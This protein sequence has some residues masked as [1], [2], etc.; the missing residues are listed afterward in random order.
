MKKTIA[1]AS[2]AG[3]F[4]GFNAFAAE[5]IITMEGPVTVTTMSSSQPAETYILEGPDHSSYTVVVPPEERIRLSKVIKE[6]PTTKFRFDGT[7]SDEEGG[8]HMFNVR[9]WERV[10]TTRSDD[11]SV[12]TETTTESR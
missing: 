2:V 6:Y 9:R 3:L 4:L 8:R 1:I 11:G 5:K 10:T 12:T 7:V